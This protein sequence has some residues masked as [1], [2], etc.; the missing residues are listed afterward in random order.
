MTELCQYL[1]SG[2]V[3]CPRWFKSGGKPLFLTE[4]FKVIVLLFLL[5]ELDR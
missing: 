5:P 2:R 1:Q 4:H 3:V